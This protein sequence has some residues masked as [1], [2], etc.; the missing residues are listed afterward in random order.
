[1]DRE[2]QTRRKEHLRHPSTKDKLHIFFRY[3]DTIKGS[4]SPKRITIQHDT[5]INKEHISR[6][7]AILLETNY[8]LTPSTSYDNYTRHIHANRALLVYYRSEKRITAY[9]NKKLRTHIDLTFYRGSVALHQRNNIF[10]I[11]DC[12]FCQ[13]VF[14]VHLV[15]FNFVK[16]IK[17]IL[18]PKSSSYFTEHIKIKMT[19]SEI[20][21]IILQL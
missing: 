4:I 1:M 12:G 19:F 14:I 21:S 8:R 6:S 7:T 20:K 5:P 2:A 10:E 17:I 18:L 15:Q 13:I 9:G 3:C 11:R 16:V